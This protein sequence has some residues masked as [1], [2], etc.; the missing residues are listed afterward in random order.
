MSARSRK[1]EPRARRRKQEK[2]VLPPAMLAVGALVI[3]VIAAM[4]FLA[5]NPPGSVG[6]IEGVIVIPDL[7]RGH[8]LEPVTY[9]QVPPA[10]GPHNPVWQNCGVYTSPIPNENAVHSLEHGVV[11]ITYDPDLPADQVERLQQI[12]RRSGYRLLSPY[13]DL[14]SPIVATAWGFQ[15]HL[16]SAD[17]PRLDDFILKYEQGPTTPEPGAVCTGGVGSPA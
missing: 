17:D 9:E 3:V 16:D 11:W 8:T 6:E 14:P 2:P 13:P 12:T 1:N 7:S 4:V 5:N 10:G 15:L